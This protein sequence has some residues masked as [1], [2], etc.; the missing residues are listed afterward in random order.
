MLLLNYQDASVIAS[1]R[2]VA[3][4]SANSPVQHC[5]P[6]GP[7][8]LERGLHGSRN[9]TRGVKSRKVQSIVA[10][11]AKAPGTALLAVPFSLGTGDVFVAGAPRLHECCN[12]A[13]FN[14]GETVL[15]ESSRE[16]E[17]CHRRDH[18]NV[19]DS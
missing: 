6:A 18:E 16:L 15:E 5:L 7:A 1:T 4:R 8:K 11:A 3:R 2:N 13:C 10:Q 12:R 14:R 17:Q 19:D 9:R